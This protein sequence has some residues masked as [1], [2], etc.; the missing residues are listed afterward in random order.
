MAYDLARGPLRF[1][2]WPGVCLG[3]RLIPVFNE[4][5]WPLWFKMLALSQVF[6]EMA[7]PLIEW[8]PLLEVWVYGDNERRG[9]WNYTGPAQVG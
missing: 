3:R 5:A 2:C 1:R 6:W 7:Y 9:S 4:L 8:R